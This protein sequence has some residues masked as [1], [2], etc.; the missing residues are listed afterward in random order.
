MKLKREPEKKDWLSIIFILLL[1]GI[2]TRFSIEY[3]SRFGGIP[4]NDLLSTGE[5]LQ[6]FVL[7]Y[8]DTGVLVIVLLHI[9]QVVL[10]VI[11]SAIVQFVG[12]M[13]YGM[14]LGMLLGIIGV[15]VGTAISFYLSRYLGQRVVSLLVSDQHLHQ[16]E[17]LISNNI[18]E[19]VLL[20]LF[21]LPFPKD[22]LAYLIGL[23]NMRAAKFFS[24][25]AVGRLPG[26]LVATY[27]GSH[28]LERN[29]VLIIS[30]A[31]AC[32]MLFL[33]M[34]AYK[35]KILHFFVSQRK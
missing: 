25:S 19:I 26:M 9:L 16:F 18:S 17:G 31:V 21:I 6:R 10:S 8:G 2:F 35:N 22:L 12:G 29:F 20:I 1:L 3:F 33:L 27:L 5:N 30:A 4:G 23:T 15:A 24:I 32:S 7:S 11:P 28:I 34:A 14:G 13:I